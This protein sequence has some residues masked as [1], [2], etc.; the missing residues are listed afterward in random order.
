VLSSGKE[1]TDTEVVFFER[2]E[3]ALV[4]SRVKMFH[5]AAQSGDSSDMKRSG[6]MVAMNRSMHRGI[7]GSAKQSADDSIQLRVF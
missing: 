1:T 4:G 6:S 7:L 5:A 2:R 3:C